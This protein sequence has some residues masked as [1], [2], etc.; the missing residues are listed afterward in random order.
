MDCHIT[1]FCL[2]CDSVRRSFSHKCP[3]TSALTSLVIDLTRVYDPFNNPSCLLSHVLTENLCSWLVGFPGLQGIV[4][5]PT[6][7]FKFNN[8]NSFLCKLFLWNSVKQNAIDF[9]DFLDR[10]L[11]AYS[12]NGQ[13][14]IL[15]QF[16]PKE[17]PEK[18][19]IEV[20][21]CWISY[22]LENRINFCF[23]KI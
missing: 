8:I 1:L 18:Q 2:W 6:E 13:L 19:Y 11:R 21:C 23:F 4:H 16:L 17:G 9:F 5:L 14:A 7:H 3:N 22:Y 12:S 10:K 20:T 15:R